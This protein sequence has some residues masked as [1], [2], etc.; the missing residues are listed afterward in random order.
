M[1]KYRYRAKAQDG[2]KIESEYEANSKE[3]V[4]GMIT[5]N[6]YYPLKIEEISS[7]PFAEISFNQKVSTK[8]L[9]IF[10]RQMYTMLDAGV[11][12]TNSL[13]MLANQVINKKLKAIVG[14]I[15]EDVK[16]GEMLSQSMA[17]YPNEFPKLLVSMVQSGE[18]TGNIDA[19]MLRMAVHFEKENRMNNKVK[20]AMI[21]PL[22]LCFVTVV[23]VAFI[24]T[25]V[26]PT[27]VS[28]FEGQGAP[29]PTITKVVIGIS[30]FLR[31]YYLYIGI[32]IILLV[33]AFNYYKKTDKGIEAIS[34]M[35][36]KMPLLA[37]L[38]KKIITAR[39]TRTMS[40]LLS[41]GISLIDALPIV[42]EIIGNRV[43]EEEL[44]RVRERIVRGEGLS[45]PINES[46]V[47]PELLSSMI[48]IGEESGSLDDILN[49]TADFYDEE[50]DQAITAA[51]AMIE[52]ALIIV[53]GLIIGSIVISIMLPMF[54][55][56]SLI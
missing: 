15:E 19:I 47:F 17:K 39:F 6:G 35:K 29:L 23:A 16:K 38:N 4:V 32:F 22:V 25:F 36:I 13:N 53:M 24:M 43:A 3:E 5:S 33:V 2:K 12:I 42:S 46:V 51:T 18:A 8:D 54:D 14:E 48:K 7:R 27:F 44:A 21:Y 1:K 45:A 56:Y 26:M 10:C 55:M 34:K 41:S 20:A 28:L 49:K 40:T 50:V 9:S 52:P 11:T 30:K 31:A 37:S